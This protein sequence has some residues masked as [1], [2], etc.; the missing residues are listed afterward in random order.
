MKLMFLVILEIFLA[1]K[2]TDVNLCKLPSANIVLAPLGVFGG[3]NTVRQS[4]ALGGFRLSP[5]S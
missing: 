5:M 3:A 4:R 2:R 1:S